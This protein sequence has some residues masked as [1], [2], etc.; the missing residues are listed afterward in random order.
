MHWKVAGLIPGQGM[1][2]RQLID[3]SLSHWCVGVSFSL[4]PPSS[5]WKQQKKVLRWGFKKKMPFATH[6][7]DFMSLSVLAASWGKVGSVWRMFLVALLSALGKRGCQAPC[8]EQHLAL[9]RIILPNN[10]PSHLCTGA[11][12][13]AWV[14]SQAATAALWK[15]LSVL[16]TS[17]QQPEP[18]KPFPS[19]GFSGASPW[20]HNPKRRSVEREGRGVA[21]CPVAS[22]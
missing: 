4:F 10:R 17:A 2:G 1:Y 9:W 22:V 7:V 14:S 11:G 21:R 5:L 3:V 19:S 16:D 18:W 13:T 8:S 6:Q 20:R 12:P 15:A